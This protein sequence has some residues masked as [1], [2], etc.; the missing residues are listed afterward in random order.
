MI[1]FIILFLVFYIL[2]IVSC[3]MYFKK[4]FLDPKGIWKNL[5]LSTSEVL[6]VFIPL[7][8]TIFGI[9]YILGFWKDEKY[10][11]TKFFN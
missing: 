1:S 6:I 7:L 4:S 9:L 3:Y 5:T 2:S 10:R 8:N 11:T